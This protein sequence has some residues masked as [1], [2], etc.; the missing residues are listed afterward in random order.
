MSLKNNLLKKTAANPVRP[1]NLLSAVIKHVVL[2]GLGAW[3]IGNGWTTESLWQGALGSVMS[4]MAYYASW[5]DLRKVAADESTK[6]LRRLGLVRHA[7]SSLGGL[8][9]AF[10]VIPADLVN[11]SVAA[12]LAFVATLASAKAPE[13]TPEVEEKVYKAEVLY[14]DMDI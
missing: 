14:D 3:L 12:A 1:F 2:G 6:L 10:P 4:F 5:N 9:L 13:K 11:A 8:L 7:I